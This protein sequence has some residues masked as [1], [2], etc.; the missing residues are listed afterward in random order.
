MSEE[1]NRRAPLKRSSWQKTRD[2]LLSRTTLCLFEVLLLWCT[3]LNIVFGVVGYFIATPDLSFVSDEC[4]LS[5]EEVERQQQYYSSCSR[6]Q[7][8]AC[9]VYLDS[10]IEAELLRIS[11][12]ESNNAV[13]ISNA[14]NTSFAYGTEYQTIL[15]ALQAWKNVNPL[16]P[17]S[18]NAQ[19]SA[20]NISWIEGA[21]GDHASSVSNIA[22]ASATYSH[23]TDARVDRLVEYSMQMRGYGAEYAH[24]KLSALSESL[25]MQV[26]L[27]KASSS[28]AYNLTKQ[29]L[30][31]DFSEVKNCLNVNISAETP[32]K[33]GTSMA[34]LYCKQQTYNIPVSISAVTHLFIL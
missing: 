29:Q 33:Y 2:V 6:S 14:E 17:L 24:E 10:A 27:S 18:F 5:A 30:L 11:Y 7:V 9:S 21:V 3:S 32:C 15:S 28:F 34:A 19:C 20:E 22:S 8:H 12:L 23:D 13:S 26:N 16:V 31:E 1:S 25:S 4:V